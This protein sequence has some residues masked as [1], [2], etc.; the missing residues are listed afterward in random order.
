M[1]PISGKIFENKEEA[2]KYR[3]LKRFTPAGQ[4]TQLIIGATDDSDRQI[5]ILSLNLYQN[6]N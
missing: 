3:H 4:I 6:P 5:L 1:K 2:K